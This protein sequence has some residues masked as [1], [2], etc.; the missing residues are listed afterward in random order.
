VPKLKGFYI[1]HAASSRDVS[2]HITRTLA[3]L[4][5]HGRGW[6]TCSTNA[7]LRGDPNRL[8][9]LLERYALVPINSGVTFHALWVLG[10]VSDG[11]GNQLLRFSSNAALQK[12]RHSPRVSDR[13]SRGTRWE[14][15][16]EE[17]QQREAD[18]TFVGDAQLLIASEKGEGTRCER[19]RTVIR[20]ENSLALDC[21]EHEIRRTVAVRQQGLARTELDY[22][23]IGL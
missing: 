3:T 5:E 8:D 9:D 22:P 11:E 19:D 20:L 16:S 17:R 15:W 14:W 12:R 1:I 2:E 21:E 6:C 10:D 13:S 4:H 18:S 23:D 7:H